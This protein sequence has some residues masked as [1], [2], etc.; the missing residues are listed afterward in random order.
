MALGFAQKV[1]CADGSWTHGEQYTLLCYTDI[2]PLLTTE[3][4]EGGRLPYLQ[5]CAPVAGSSCDE[6]PVGSMYF[7]R[8]AA[9]VSGGGFARFFSVNAA[10]LTACALVT[11]TCLYL[12]VR[13]RALYFA[14]A[15]TLLIYGYV[16]WDLL[17]VALST[18]ALVAFFV[19]R[20]GLSGTLMGLGVAAKLYPL[21]L[22]VPLVA[23]RIKE[24]EPDRAIVFAWW[25][26][27][28]WAIVNLP[29][30]VFGAAG[31]WTFFSFNSR[32][33][34]DWDSLWFIACRH[35]EATCIP[36]FAVNTLSLL[37]FL[38][39]SALVWRIKQMRDPQFPMWTLGFPLLALF[40]LT[41]KVYSPQY[42]LWLLPW[43]ALALPDLRRFV[44]FEAADVLVFVS[45]FWFFGEL[46]GTFGIPQWLFEIAVLARALVLLWCLAGWIKRRAEP[47]PIEI[48]E[49][50]PQAP[51]CAPERA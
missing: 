14:L 44:A 7:M 2:V 21:I 4:L 28:S 6:Y 39:A 1:P 49:R 30:A 25:T 29:F 32:R 26:I 12:A 27:G 22:A 42:G 40:L 43:F 13:E 24:R 41:N 31:W 47:L 38:T 20:E 35:V 37:L 45:R 48:P 10:L 17:A 16:N 3:Q 51:E 34:P 9:W 11:A 33:P 15:P 23:Q 46:E 19:R 18:G 36:T 50:E 5:P 8:L